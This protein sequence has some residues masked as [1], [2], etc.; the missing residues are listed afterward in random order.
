MNGW[1]EL[2]AVRLAGRADKMVLLI[3]ALVGRQLVVS[4]VAQKTGD[5]RLELPREINE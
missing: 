5:G 3:S 4:H 2:V 1:Q